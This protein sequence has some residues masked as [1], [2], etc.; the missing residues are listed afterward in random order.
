MGIID[1]VIIALAGLLAV[2][3][4][5]RG[6][7]KELF[8]LGGWIIS[9]GVAFFLSNPVAP[10]V[11]SMTGL[12]AGFTA[13]ALTFVGL[14]LVSFIIIKIISHSLSKSIQKG[15]LGFVDRL[16]GIVWGLGKALIIIGLLFLAADYLKTLPFVGTT[17]TNFM[18][19]DL[20]LET[21]TMGIGRYLYENNYA[22]MLINYAMAQFSA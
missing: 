11:V 12:E 9:I 13:N 18:T 4:M 7:V 17:I 1:I 2:I 20:K 21:E 16:F 10:I 8:S 6:F 3:G 15:A 14:F 5:F 19:S 22:K